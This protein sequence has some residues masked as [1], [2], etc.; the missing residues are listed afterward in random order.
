MITPVCYTTLNVKKIDNQAGKRYNMG[1]CKNQVFKAKNVMINPEDAKYV[2]ERLES[3]KNLDASPV[4]YIKELISN[5]LNG[6]IEA[7]EFVTSYIKKS[8]EAKYILSM[9]SADDIKTNQSLFKKELTLADKLYNSLKDK[10][11]ENR[12]TVMGIVKS[13]F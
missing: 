10:Q 5:F 6:Q 9:M 11:S 1:I 8:N 3:Y 12:E 2:M 13:A 7:F 4:K